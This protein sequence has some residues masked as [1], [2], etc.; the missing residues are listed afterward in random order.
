MLTK[1]ILTYAFKSGNLTPSEASLPQLSCGNADDGSQVYQRH[2]GLRLLQRMQKNLE[3]RFAVQHPQYLHSSAAEIRITD[4]ARCLLS[5]GELHSIFRNINNFN[6]NLYLY[7]YQ[8]LSFP[9]DGVC[10]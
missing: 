3:I 6:F 2:G 8:R 1:R 4:F 10:L 5:E 9:R 7:F